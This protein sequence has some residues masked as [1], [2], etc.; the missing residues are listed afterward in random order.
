M[1]VPVLKEVV[2]LMLDGE[3][4]KS[5]KEA[6]DKNWTITNPHYFEQGELISFHSTDKHIVCIE[7][8]PGVSPDESNYTIGV[9]YFYEDYKPY[10]DEWIKPYNRNKLLENILN[11]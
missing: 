7:T 6:I 9:A 5:R 11:E 3:F 8:Q 1:K 10:Y 4:K 2:Q